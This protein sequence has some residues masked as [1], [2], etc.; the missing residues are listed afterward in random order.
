MS[1]DYYTYIQSAEWRERANVAKR[2]VG[3]RCQVCNRPA[4]SVTLEAHHRTYERLGK[5][6]PEDLTVLCRDCH[7]LYE[8]NK[9]LPQPPAPQPVQPAPPEIMLA[10]T[11]PS[12]PVIL[13]PRPPLQFVPV[14]SSRKQ[15]AGANQPAPD[16]SSLAPDSVYR[17]LP[18]ESADAD[19]RQ[20]QPTQRAPKPANRAARDSK[21]RITAI[22][23]VLAMLAAISLL[24]NGP[25]PTARPAALRATPQPSVASTLAA[26]QTAMPNQTTI[27][28]TPIVA[29]DPPTATVPA[30]IP[31]LAV[32]ATTES[33]PTSA[34]SATDTRQGIVNQ[35]ALVC[36]T[37]CSCAPVVRTIAQGS[38]VSILETQRC[39]LDTWVRIADGEWLGPRFI[40]E[41]PSE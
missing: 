13:S 22:L 25:S 26:I 6:R 21:I 23:L 8:A 20:L 41:V 14:K 30:A 3:N 38:Q 31:T 28:E 33:L 10:T 37:P 39:G 15:P 19:V 34:P 4:T 2:R 24:D 11:Q 1:V 18:V 27:A 17:L 16:S 36:Q 29:V 40:E 12:E 7:A 5:E 35:S 9:R 32:T